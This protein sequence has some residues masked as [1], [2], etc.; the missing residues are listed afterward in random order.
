MDP[1]KGHPGRGHSPRKGWEVRQAGRVWTAAGRQARQ[2]RWARGGEEGRQGF[3]G[4]AGLWVIIQGL[5]KSGEDDVCIF[6][7]IDIQVGDSEGLARV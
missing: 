7:Q 1:C 4:H 6:L 2:M 5:E 3:L